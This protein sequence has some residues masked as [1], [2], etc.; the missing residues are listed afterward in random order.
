MGPI[1]TNNWKNVTQQIGLGNGAI[2]VGYDDLG[3]ARPQVYHR[4][5]LLRR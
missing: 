4:R 3:E 2:N 1:T 5:H